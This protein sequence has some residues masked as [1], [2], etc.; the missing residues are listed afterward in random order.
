MAIH[1]HTAALDPHRLRYGRGASAIR[2]S[3]D[4]RVRLG[5]TREAF[6][7]IEKRLHGKRSKVRQ[8]HTQLIMASVPPRERLQPFGNVIREALTHDTGRIAHHN[9]I[10][11]D[12][13][14]HD[15]TGCNHGAGADA[16][17]G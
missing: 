10:R 14:G 8:S 16:A 11:G 5:G 17:P 2:L 13:L 4:E 1:Q 7:L 3:T 9:G 15:G 12:I 6:E